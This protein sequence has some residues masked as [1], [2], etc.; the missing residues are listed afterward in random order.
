MLK[1]ILNY[2]IVSVMSSIASSALAEDCSIPLSGITQIEQ[3]ENNIFIQFDSGSSSCSCAGVDTSRV[4]FNKAAYE[5]FF[6]S[7][8]LTALV[9]GKGAEAMGHNDDC[10][11][12]AVKLSRL[13]LRVLNK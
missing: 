4:W 8:G 6:I 10:V 11:E 5:K 7:A 1:K 13:T 9:T 3:A 2:L 12:G